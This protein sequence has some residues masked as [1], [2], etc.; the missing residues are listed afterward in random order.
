MGKGGNEGA[1]GF[2]IHGGVF[3]ASDGDMHG[4]AIYEGTEGFH[5]VVSET[6]CVVAAV[7][8]YAEGTM[9]AA[10]V[11]APVTQWLH[12]VEG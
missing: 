10:V 4:G 2:A 5:E 9:K 3:P 6:E 11:N 8:M 7:V 12:P 1:F